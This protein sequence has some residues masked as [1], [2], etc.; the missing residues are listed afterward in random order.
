[1]LKGEAGEGKATS[2]IS[3][4][5]ANELSTHEAV[6]GKPESNIIRR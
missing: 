1:M 5:S 2:M 3:P 4:I 6:T